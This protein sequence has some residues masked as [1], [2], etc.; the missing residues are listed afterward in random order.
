MSKGEAA[1]AAFLADKKTSLAKP[2]QSFASV[3]EI[4]ADKEYYCTATWGIMSLMAAP[5]FW[6]KTRQIKE[7]VAELPR[8]QCVGISVA[9]TPKWPFNFVAETLTVWHDRKYSTAFYKSELHR[10][11]MKALQGRV[12]FRAHRV[13]VKGSDL[14]VNGNA[15]STSEFWTAVKMGEKFRKVETASG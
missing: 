6:S 3:E 9:V 11:G 8:G 12:E 10:E 7:S 1:T 15:S 4:D 5:T 13:W 2:W 14:P